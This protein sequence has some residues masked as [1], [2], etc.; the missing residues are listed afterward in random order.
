MNAVLSLL[1]R[2]QAPTVRRLAGVALDSDFAERER[3]FRRFGGDLPAF[4]NALRKR[5]LVELSEELSLPS[6]GRVGHLRE[7]LWTWGAELEAGGR[8]VLGTAVQPRP[9]VLK[10]KLVHLRAEPAIAPEPQDL[11]RS[12]PIPV[13]R[14]H[15]VGEPDT[16]DELLNRA[17]ALL[18]V[19]LGERGRDKGAYGSSIAALLGV[20][21]EGLSEPDW[22]GEVEIKSVPVVRD[23]GGMWWVKEDPAVSMEA[24]RPLA[25]LTRVLWIARIADEQDSPILSWFY[26]ERTW[27]LEQLQTRDLHTRPKGGKGTRA[28]GWYLHKRYF[29]D[30]GLLLTLNGE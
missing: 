20:A 25:K 5:E 19:R 9:Q 2:A 11:P 12:V 1:R 7:R 22:R 4:L 16:I 26:Q 6:T 15:F 10:D 28:R 30:C 8:D 3:A 14:P 27:R 21:E 24:A 17:N 29:A 23:R 13:G 18:G